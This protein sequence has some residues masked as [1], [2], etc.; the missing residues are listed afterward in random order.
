MVQLMRKGF[1]NQMRV[2]YQ[3]YEPATLLIAEFAPADWSAEAPEKMKWSQARVLAFMK[4]VLPGW[5][6]RG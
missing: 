4:E 5:K 6:S 3:L 1:K 2:A